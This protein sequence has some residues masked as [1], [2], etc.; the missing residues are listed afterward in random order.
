M[1]G[2]PPASLPETGGV[3]PENIEDEAVQ[4]RVAVMAALVLLAAGALIAGRAVSGLRR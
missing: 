3:P 4:A 2:P 1:F